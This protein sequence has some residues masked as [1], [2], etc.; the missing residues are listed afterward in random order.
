MS[1]SMDQIRMAWRE[2]FSSRN[3]S[4]YAVPD[5]DPNS[6]WNGWVEEVFN[7]FVL[8]SGDDAYTGQKF[9]AVPYTVEEGGV[10]FGAATPVKR[11][12]VPAA[13]ASSV[14]SVSLSSTDEQ[15]RLVSY[16][17]V[18]DGTLYLSDRGVHVMVDEDEG[19]AFE[20]PMPDAEIEDVLAKVNAM[21]AHVRD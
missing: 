8:V 20:P 9:W 21:L 14:S 16:G 5:R 19:D 12:Y 2:Q 11:V 7:D 6:P 15:H 17:D 10:R 3:N 1:W 4:D 13:S 18:P